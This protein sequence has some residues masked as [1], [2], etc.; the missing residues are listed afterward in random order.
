MEMLSKQVIKMTRSQ[1]TKI[2]IEQRQAG[3][4]SASEFDHCLSRLAEI[5]T[6]FVYGHKIGWR[7]QQRKYAIIASA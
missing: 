6:G 2:V 3:L 5:A 7:E 4:L 1:A